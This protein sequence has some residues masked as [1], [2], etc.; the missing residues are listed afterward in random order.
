MKPEV[1]RAGEIDDNA[2]FAAYLDYLAGYRGAGVLPFDVSQR[3][4]ITVSNQRQEPILD[5]QVRIYAGQQQLFSGRTYAGGTTIF[6]PAAAH[7][8]QIGEL[9]LVAEK[10]QSRSEQLIQPGSRR[11]DLVLEDAAGPRTPLQVDLVFLLD[12]TG[13][14]GDEIGRL[15]QTIGDIAARIDR[16]EPRPDLRFGLVSYRDRG[17]EYVARIDADFTGDVN[18]FSNALWQVRADGGGDTPEDLN[19]GLRLAIE[20]LR[21]RDDAVRLVFLVADAAPQLGYGQQFDYLVGAREAVARGIRIY[22][23]AASNTDESAEYVFRQL[24]QQTLGR[25]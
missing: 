15:Q 14:M 10:G 20:E 24:A 8:S 23:I 13:S 22:P 9:R 5:A 6:F 1:I 3:I 4:L 21:W 17:D 19:E 2:D 12:A 18:R 16:I 7:S 25:F 11:V